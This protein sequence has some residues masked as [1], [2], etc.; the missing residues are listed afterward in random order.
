MKNLVIFAAI[1]FLLATVYYRADLSTLTQPG[2][3]RNRLL[4]A[5]TP[6]LAPSLDTADL[7]PIA[8]TS[9][10]PY[11]VNTFLEQEVD[12]AKLRQTLQLVRDAGF[13]WIRQEFPWRDIEISAKGDY[14][15][16]KWN[17]SAWDKYD[18]IVT[19]A[20]EYGLNVIARLDAPPDWSRQDNR[21]FYRPPDNYA[22]FGDYVS[23]VVSRYRG[24]VRYYQIW[25]E[26]NIFPE[27]GYQDVKASEY[28]PLLQIAYRRA[29]EADPSCV[30]IAAALAPT[31]AHEPMNRSDVLF[32]QEM[33]DAGARDSFDILSTM[34]YGLISGPD[35]RRADPWRDVN[36][37]RPMLLRQVMV[38][39]GDAQKPIWISELGWNTLPAGFPE[40]PRYGRVTDDQQ[41]RYTL[42]GLQRIGQEWPWVGVVNVWYL[43]Q[44]GNWQNTQQEYYF[45]MI[46][47][48]FTVH[49][50]YEAVQSFA[51]H[52]PVL[53]RGY[54]QEDSY[55]LTFSG[56]W[57]SGLHPRA[58]LGAYRQGVTAGS[59]LTFTFR[60]TDLDL[61]T[62]RGPDGGLLWVEVDSAPASDR[63][64]PRDAAGR[65]YA[66][67]GAS[68]EEWQALVPLAHGLADGEHRVTLTV[69]RGS[70]VVDG[71]IV[72]RRP[73]FPGAWFW[74]GALLVALWGGFWRTKR[75]IG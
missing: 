75:E 26:P 33:Y 53:E 70:V 51:T 64:L 15:D 62:R 25:N 68:P 73:G 71:L 44:P 72:D 23:A 37:S 66:D 12:E 69:G 11:G 27:W 34:A 39:N 2:E 54:R 46:D 74:I 38:R 67:L 6:F 14:W 9:L 17:Q 57:W 24:K 1:F 42:R 13:S 36:F 49:P 56:S 63:Q 28:T 35:D 30:I 5:G 47:P 45:R 61:V 59:T 41:A 32:L 21:I 50:V 60:G 58:S 31:I 8:H 55:A 48:D 16:H 4:A 29:K 19:L 20:G 65:A 3:L 52:P 10:S 7:S 22:D 40:P 18:R 43:R